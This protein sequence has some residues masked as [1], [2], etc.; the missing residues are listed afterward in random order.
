[1]SEITPD[2]LQALLNFAS[3][4]LGTTPEKLAKTVTEGNLGDLTGHMDPQNAAKIN[5]MVSDRSKAEQLL[6][7]P[8]AQQLINQFLG[9]QGK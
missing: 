7:T 1:M 2:Q 3:K 4:K 8:Q 5:E 9:G 6:R